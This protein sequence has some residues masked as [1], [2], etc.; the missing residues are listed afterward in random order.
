VVTVREVL[1][2]AIGGSVVT[3]LVLLAWPWARINGRFLIAGIGTIPGTV[4][5]NLALRNAQAS[6]LDVDG[7][8]AHLSFQDVGSGVLAFVSVALVLGFITER[9]ESAVKIVSVAGIAGIVIML[10]DIFV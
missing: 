3:A 4:A 7:P 1:S 10:F 9:S 6:N 2:V 5:W 8:V